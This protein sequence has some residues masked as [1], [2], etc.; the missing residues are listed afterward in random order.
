MMHVRSTHHHVLAVLEEG[1]GSLGV[2][3]LVDE[4]QLLG[5]LRRDLLRDLQ[6]KSGSWVVWVRVWGR[7]SK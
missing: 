6:C 3:G 2:V 5:Q 4:V 7:V 1:G